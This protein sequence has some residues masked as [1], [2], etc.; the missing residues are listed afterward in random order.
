MK[1]LLGAVTLSLLAWGAAP[2]NAA[3]VGSFGV[4]PDSAA[5]AF[6][7]DPNGAGVGGLFNDFFTFTLN[8]TSFVTVANATNTFAR[9]GIT[10]TFGIQQFAAAIFDTVD[11]IVDNG[12]DVL[13]FG[14]QA[15]VINP[16]GLS[17]SLNGIGKL[18]GGDYYLRIAGNAGTQAGYGGNFSVSAVPIPAALPLFGTAL[19]GLFY[20]K[21]RSRKHST[22]V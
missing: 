1:T 11:G 21:R 5:G 22:P 19:G 15:A 10:G 2:A 6:Q 17:Q 3:V 14:P 16:G 9:G 4:N 20:L 18:P 13:K 7:N 8:G 12:N